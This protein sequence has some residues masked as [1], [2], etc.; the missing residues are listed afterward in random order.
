LKQTEISLQVCSKILLKFTEISLKPS[1]KWY[2]KSTLI[3]SKFYRIDVDL[4]SIPWESV[5]KLKT[6]SAKLFHHGDMII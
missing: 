4:T 1:E 3:R 5:R 6:I 2:I